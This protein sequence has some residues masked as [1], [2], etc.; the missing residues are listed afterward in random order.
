MKRDRS[1]LS[2]DELGLLLSVCE[3]KAEDEIAR[4]KER[5]AAFEAA[6]E[7]AVVRCAEPGCVAGHVRNAR[8]GTVHMFNCRR[9]YSCAWGRSDCV[10]MLYGVFKHWCD[11]HAGHQLNVRV[12]GM[13][14]RHR[15]TYPHE[16]PTVCHG[17]IPKMRKQDDCTCEWV[18]Q[19]GLK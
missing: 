1:N 7:G 9:M 8:A 5:L 12:S 18:P 19:E 6:A 15:T 2:R 17:C 3:Q 13:C 4:L 10:G 11:T 16:Q 14:T